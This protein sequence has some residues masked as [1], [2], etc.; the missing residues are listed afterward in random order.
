MKV[1]PAD[2]ADERR[3]ADIYRALTPGLTRTATAI[4]GDPVLADDVVQETWLNAIRGLD[5]FRGDADFRTWI[6][7]ILINTSRTRLR[8]L[9]RTLS[10]D[11]AVPDLPDDRF[12]GDGSWAIPPNLWD[13][14]TPERIIAGREAWAIVQEAISALPDGER[15]VLTLHEA[16]A[17]TPAQIAQATGLNAPHVR[18]LL[19]RAREHVRRSLDA[20]QDHERIKRP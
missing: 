9:G 13:E 12:S 3:F 15:V 17:M 8:G 19:H 11:A 2:L 16:E 1:S 4:T 14:L 20:A 6:T 5:G 7:R 18:K 10:I